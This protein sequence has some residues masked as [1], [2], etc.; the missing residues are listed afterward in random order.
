LDREELVARVDGDRGLLCRIV[1]L[2]LVE[3]PTKLTAIRAAIDSNDTALVARLAHAI[4]GAVGNFYSEKA[5][6]AALQLETI[7]R[8][9]DL[10]PAPRAFAE[11]TQA[12]EDITP[13][14]VLLAG[15]SVA[16]A[17][18]TFQAPQ[19]ASVT[20]AKLCEVNVVGSPAPPGD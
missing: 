4:K 3:T 14:L 8:K 5:T 6:A 20:G 15:G 12:I 11:L 13:D 2:F 1:S 9:G 19:C 18:R 17:G 10:F 7:A 16:T